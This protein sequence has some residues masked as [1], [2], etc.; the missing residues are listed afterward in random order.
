MARKNRVIETIV[1]LPGLKKRLHNFRGADVGYL[2]ETTGSQMYANGLT[3]ASNAQIQE[4]GTKFIPARPFMREGADRYETDFGAIKKTLIA[5]ADDKLTAEQ[6][7][8]R[9]GVMLQG[10]IQRA[11]VDGNWAPL[12]AQTIKRKGSSK[13]LI[14]TGR[15]RQGVDVRTK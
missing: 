12:T 5:V 10:H 9:L 6:G 2:A 14:D 1:E 11:I 3:L 7:S 13:P 4:Y 15:L 8:N